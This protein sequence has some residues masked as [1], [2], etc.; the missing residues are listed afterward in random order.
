[1]EFMFVLQPFIQMF[2]LLMTIGFFVGMIYIIYTC[3]NINKF[4]KENREKNK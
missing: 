2:T 1:M 3:V 4:L